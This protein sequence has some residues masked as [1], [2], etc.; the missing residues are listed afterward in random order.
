[1]AADTPDAIRAKA[2]DVEHDAKRRAIVTSIGQ[3]NEPDLSVAQMLERYAA[4][5]EALAVLHGLLPEPK[6]AREVKT[7]CAYALTT[8]WATTYIASY[9]DC[10]NE[11]ARLS[12]T[13][14]L[15]GSDATLTL[16]PGAD[17]RPV[18]PTTLTFLE[19]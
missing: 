6:I 4:L 5:V 15:E 13:H 11:A 17:I 3:D 12:L 10:W 16:V 8:P 18:D 2:K 7:G 14:P 1:M 19:T 9:A